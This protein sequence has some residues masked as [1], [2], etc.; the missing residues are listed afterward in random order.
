MSLNSNLS[1]PLTP[2]IA[3]TTSKASLNIPT[4]IS[5]TTPIDGDIW[6]DS[7]QKAISDNINGVTQKLS[8]CIFTA[9]GNAANSNSI[10]LLTI[11]GTGIGTKTLPANFWV[12]GKTIR[13][14]AGGVISNTGTPTINTVAFIGATN[15][16]G[17]GAYITTTGL[18]NV[19]FKVEVYMTC[20][21]TGVTG[22]VR[23][24]TNVWI[25]NSTYFSTGAGNTTIDTTALN[26]LDIQTQWG[27]ASVSNAII[28]TTCIIEILN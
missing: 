23:G 14:T 2:I 16:A 18:S 6:Y 15:V 3:S 4:G 5:P 21:S 24:Q 10:A 8:G 12:I 11:I 20:R 1:N 28:G 19:G 9:T 13:I 26:I 17:T 22:T 7:T 27:T 25:N